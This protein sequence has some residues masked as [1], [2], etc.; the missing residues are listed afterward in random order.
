VEQPA[1]RFNEVSKRQ[2]GELIEEQL[3]QSKATEIRWSAK[4]GTN[5]IWEIT[6]SFA[7]GGETGVATW[8]FDPRKYLLTPETANA[9][10][11]SSSGNKLDNLHGPTTLQKNAKPV[12][13]KEAVEVISEDNLLAFRSRRI[14]AQEIVPDVLE[15][16]E[17][18][19]EV[20]E[21]IAAAEPGPSGSEEQGP[22]T[23]AESTND[24]EESKPIEPKKVRAPMPSWDQI[25][26]GTQSDDGEAF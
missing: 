23:A 15:L 6:V 19:P 18:S 3:S 7:S 17:I 1:D 2:F 16:K 25:V 22:A 11:L 21:E 4:R 20:P 26:R 13:V 14:Q 8:T 9:A 10:S 24:S 5:A 12:S